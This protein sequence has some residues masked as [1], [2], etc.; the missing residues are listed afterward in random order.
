MID[1][2]VTFFPVGNGD[3]TLIRLRGGQSIL[4]DCNFRSDETVYDVPGYL[5]RILQPSRK[6][7][8]YLD[9]FALTHPDQDHARG[10]GAVFFHGDPAKYTDDDRQ[11]GRIR[12][13][14][15]WFTPRLLNEGPNDLCDDVNVVR[16]EVRRR[17]KVYQDRGPTGVEPGNRLRLVGYSASDQLKGLER[18]RTVAGQVIDRIN[19]TPCDDFRFFVYAPV[20]ADSD[21]ED[22]D[23]NA[24]CMV[25][26]GR[27]DVARVQN[28]DRV[29]LG[30]DTACEGWKRIV[31]MNDADNMT[32]DLFLAPHHCSWGFFSDQPA[33]SK[34]EPW[35]TSIYLLAQKRGAGYIIASC[36]GIE[37]DDIDPPNY[38]AAQIY[39]TTVG[40]GHF[41]CTAGDPPEKNPQP[42]HF[43]M[44]ANGPQLSDLPGGATASV[45]S[46]LWGATTQP[47]TYG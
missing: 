25:L 43:I 4:I 14:E 5:R 36:K 15:L 27:F 29:F 17:I 40:R 39:K 41:L 34:A 24:T 10:F 35:R 21:D 19:E 47:R 46:A 37:D 11:A 30:G 38:R 45:A 31:G 20:K 3:T 28:A 44:T 13:D 16:R 8:P 26:Q 1:P 42:I 22:S 33:K 32:W 6:A 9:V 23:R 18:V 12:I 2:S 7:T